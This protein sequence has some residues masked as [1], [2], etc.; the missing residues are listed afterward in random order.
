MI[1]E[2]FTEVIFYNVGY[3]FLK[4]ISLGK[5]PPKYDA[6]NGNSFIEVAGCFITL[7]IISILCVLMF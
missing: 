2:F 3:V 6:M 1:I 5:Y 4:G 7:V